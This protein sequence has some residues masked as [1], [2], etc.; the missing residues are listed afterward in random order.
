MH[1]LQEQGYSHLAWWV[2]LAILGIEVGRP[3]SCQGRSGGA[4]LLSISGWLEELRVSFLGLGS[5]GKE[6]G[7]RLELR[8]DPM[9][10]RLDEKQAREGQTLPSLRLD[11][12]AL[13]WTKL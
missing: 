3:M 9:G 11:L 12:A 7:L 1:L 6:V 13:D 10:G 5:T 2:K 8:S 4:A